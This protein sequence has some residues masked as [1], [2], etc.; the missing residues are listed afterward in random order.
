MFGRPPQFQVI[1]H[2]TKVQCCYVQVTGGQTT[3]RQ[4]CD[5]RIVS[6]R[7]IPAVEMMHVR[8]LYTEHFLTFL[9][10]DL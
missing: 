4:T 7:I 3:R 1:R 2:N 8:Q 6:D 9:S 5:A 10:T